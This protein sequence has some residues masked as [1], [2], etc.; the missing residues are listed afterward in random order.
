MF[1]GHKSLCQKL[2]EQNLNCIADCLLVLQNL[3]HCNIYTIFI[4][5]PQG[6][7]ASETKIEH[8]LCVLSQ[9]RRCEDISAQ[10][11]TLL[12]DSIRLWKQNVRES[13]NGIKILDAPSDS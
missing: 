4:T 6:G 5:V 11:Y 8:V 10:N 3:K 9:N 1:Y 12:K 2:A 13:Q 7:V